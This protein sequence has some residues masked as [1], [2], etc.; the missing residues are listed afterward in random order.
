[1]APPR[2]KPSAQLANVRYDIRGPLARRALEL[3]KSGTPII[4]LNIGNPGAF[5]FAMPEHL[6][7]AVIDHVPQSEAYSHQKGILSA[8]EAVAEQQRARGVAVSPD[9]VFIGNGVS[10]LIMMALRGLLDDGDE[11]LVP[12]PDY[13]LWTAAVTI[14]SGR[15]V[16]YP[17]PRDNGFLPDIDALRKLVTSRTRALVIITP[18][19]PTG[20]VYP[21]QLLEAMVALAE[22]HGLLVLSDE[23]YDQILYDG[24]QHVPLATLVTKT[25]CG[26]FAG[27]SKVHRGCGLRVGWLSFSGARAAADE[28]LLALDLLASLRLCGNITGQWTV[29]AA[30]KGPDTISALTSPGGRLYQT[31]AAIIA[32]ARKSAYLDVVAPQGAMYAFVRA[33]RD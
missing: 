16:H 7:R 21:R 26:T 23:I 10:E 2:L 15:A 9:D 25:L 28:Y 6:R 24:A 14:N 31:R 3:E 32:G 12:S 1:M 19:N 8:R 27:L 13:P 17:C 20:A 18:N 33:R 30:L 11:V 5:G 29:A 4:K 22:E